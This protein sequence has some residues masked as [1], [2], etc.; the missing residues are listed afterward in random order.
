V[1][2]ESGEIA[3]GADDMVKSDLMFQGMTP[4]VDTTFYQPPELTDAMLNTTVFIDPSNPFSESVQAKV[5]RKVGQLRCIFYTL[6]SNTMILYI[7]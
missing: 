4:V 6:Y 5:L 1:R 7:F 3:A 2:E